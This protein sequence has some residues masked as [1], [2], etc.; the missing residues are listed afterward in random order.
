MYDVIRALVRRLELLDTN[1]LVTAVVDTRCT[2]MGIK[3][4][5][6]YKGNTMIKS[7]LEMIVVMIAVF[8]FITVLTMGLPIKPDQDWLA[9]RVDGG[10]DRYGN[11]YL[12]VKR[13]EWMERV[14][15]KLIEIYPL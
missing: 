6:V 15:C 3:C 4:V 2:D 10:Q 12:Y 1:G 14:D 11:C 9:T 13:W 8:G 5:Y 7:W